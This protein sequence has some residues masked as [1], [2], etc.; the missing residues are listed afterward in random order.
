MV[1]QE[2]AEALR[3]MATLTPESPRRRHLLQYA[4]GILAESRV[5]DSR[6]ETEHALRLELAG[7]TPAVDARRAVRHPPVEPGDSD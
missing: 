2:A 6:D 4:E 5:L 7:I 1:W 3:A